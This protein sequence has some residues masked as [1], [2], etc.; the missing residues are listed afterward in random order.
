MHPQFSKRTLDNLSNVT[1]GLVGGSHS[2]GSGGTK[3]QVPRRPSYAKATEGKAAPRMAA[4]ED[5]WYVTVLLAERLGSIAQC[6][7]RPRE[8]VS[9]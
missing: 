6:R 3:K 4:L 9:P 5:Y 2:S 7:V 8:P 1:C